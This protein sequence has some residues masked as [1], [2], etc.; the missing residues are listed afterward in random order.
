MISNTDTVKS[1]GFFCGIIEE[2]RAIILPEQ[3][4]EVSRD[5]FFEA[6]F[7]V[8]KTTKDQGLIITLLY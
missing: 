8:S 4:Q 7:P 1:T 5:V 2:G 3:S 6:E